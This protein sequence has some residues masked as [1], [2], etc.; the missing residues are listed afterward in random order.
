MHKAVLLFLGVEIVHQPRQLLRLRG[1]GGWCERNTSA[2]ASVQLFMPPPCWRCSAGWAAAAV[3][4]LGGRRGPLPS[5]PPRRASKRAGAGCLPAPA[6]CSYQ[7]SA[8]G[9]VSTPCGAAPH[10][11]ACTARP[12]GSQ[13]SG[14][15]GVEQLR[16][17][18]AAA[19]G[20]HCL[21]SSSVVNSTSGSWHCTRKFSK[22]LGPLNT[23]STNMGL[24]Q[25]GR[26][27]GNAAIT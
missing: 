21:Y 6:Q 26:G 3:R 24:R 22:A 12:A 11:P 17:N 1:G 5:N 25:G 23:G 9:S 20:T 16:N 14:A 8:Q 4:W 10:R 15:A 19:A 7:P 27:V 18:H 2:S 13:F